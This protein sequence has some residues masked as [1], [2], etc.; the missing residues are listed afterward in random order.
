MIGGLFRRGAAFEAFLS[1]ARARAAIWRTA[2]GA[3]LAAALIFGASVGV[4][5]A[6]A[7]LSPADL[8]VLAFLDRPAGVAATLG[9]F[10]IW[11]I[12]LAIVLRLL[13]R[14]RLRSLFGA[15]S[16]LRPFLAGF[17][18]AMAFNLVGLALGWAIA[19]APELSVRPLGLW[20]VWA[21]LALPLVLLQTGAEEA[22]F[23]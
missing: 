3:L 6:L 22:V 21:V 12:A 16:G 19:G 13:H 2:L 10:A 11:W 14:R 1:P 17:A 18:A 20:L 5:L 4:G 8:D 9:S 23:R 7:F 15:G